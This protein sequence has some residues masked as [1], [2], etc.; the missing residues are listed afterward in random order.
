MCVEAG[1]AKLHCAKPAALANEKSNVMVILKWRMQQVFSTAERAWAT[2]LQQMI[3]PGTPFLKLTAQ[4]TLDWSQKPT[5]KK[6]PGIAGP[7]RK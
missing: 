6:R 2:V 1:E 5:A 3:R 7:L 4:I